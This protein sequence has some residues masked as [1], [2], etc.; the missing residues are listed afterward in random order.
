[1]NCKL[2]KLI[3]FAVL[4]LI[5][6]GVLAQEG[7]TV[8]NYRAKVLEY[9]QVLKQ[10]RQQT[11]ASVAKQKVNKTGF[12]PTLD[13]NAQGTLDLTELNAWRGDEGV[14]RNNTYYGQLILTQPLYS[15]GAIRSQYK[16]SEIETD[17][18]RQ[19]QQLTLENITYQADVVFWTA[20]ANVELFSASKEYYDIV[21][22]QHD[23]ISIRFRDGM[24]GKT[25]LLMITTRLKEAELQLSIARKSCTL[26]FQSLNILMGMQP[27]DQVNLSDTISRPLFL[28]ELLPL[29][30][31]LKRRPDFRNA[32]MNIAL[33]D[34]YR[35]LAVSK[36][37]PQLG[38]SVSGGWGTQT[39]NFGIQEEFSGL[40]ALSLNV[41]LVYWG[42]RR[43]TNAQ[44]KSAILISEL[45][46][47]RI[48]D[49][50]SSELSA[51]WT[52]ITQTREQIRL[53]GENLLLA[54]E[55]LDLITY[56]YN[57]GKNPIVDVLSAQLTWINAYTSRI[58]AYLGHKIAMSDYNKA[59]GSVVAR[60]E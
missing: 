34:Q 24:I 48:E 28:P 49:Q 26:A 6:E 15:G 8:E 31:V 58:S 54:E 12:L 56:S 53:S 44:S 38:L 43:Q 45:E 40:A 55:N 22:T 60:E 13:F 23:V 18:T 39:P 30:E 47:D 7:L 16:A 5:A 11:F 25:D 33:Q 41:P 51:A 4:V 52:N 50:I 2:Y 21:K 35:K 32:Q 46:M 9:S 17:M 42:A 29:Q 59:I 57:E 14:Y 36:Y 3:L 37:N 1:M 27:D 19:T 10:A 20:A